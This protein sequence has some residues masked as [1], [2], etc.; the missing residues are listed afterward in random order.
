MDASLFIIP[1]HSSPSLWLWLVRGWQNLSVKIQSPV[2]DWTRQLTKN[3]A[4]TYS[5]CNQLHFSSVGLRSMAMP[6]FCHSDLLNVK[7][8]CFWGASVLQPFWWK[9][10]SVDVN[11][12]CLFSCLFTANRLWCLLTTCRLASVSA[13]IKPSHTWSVHDDTRY[14][15]LQHMACRWVTLCLFVCFCRRLPFASGWHLDAGWRW[16]SGAPIPRPTPWSLGLP[17]HHTSRGWH[18]WRHTLLSQAGVHGE[19]QQRRGVIHNLHPK[20]C[21]TVNSVSRLMGLIGISL[22]SGI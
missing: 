10:L 3:I 22:H 1:A 12:T 19:W 21:T 17:T 6:Q 11:E 9:W 14:D 15:A 4:H 16:P 18:H 8:I 7:Q 2:R 20:E 5:I 13:V